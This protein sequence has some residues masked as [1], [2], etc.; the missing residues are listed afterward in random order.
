MIDQTIVRE[1]VTELEKLPEDQVN[2]VLDFVRFLRSRTA[3]RVQKRREHRIFDEAK[4]A[5]L[6]AEAEEEDR[7]L[8]E[9][10]MTDYTS[11]LKTEDADA[12]R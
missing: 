5:E 6:Y 10:G 12:K 8:A 11:S 9:S 7:K 3:Y 2:E 1:I 4:A